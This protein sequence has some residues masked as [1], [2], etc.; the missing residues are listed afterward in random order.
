MSR[1][2]KLR[3]TQFRLGLLPPSDRD[4]L[5]LMPS[6]NEHETRYEIVQGENPWSGTKQRREAGTL[7]T[8]F[9]FFLF[10]LFLLRLSCDWLKIWDQV[11]VMKRKG[12]A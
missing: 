2:S 7:E 8:T 11:L 10:D 5:A 3:A 12:A 6:H 9:V 1:Y 4:D